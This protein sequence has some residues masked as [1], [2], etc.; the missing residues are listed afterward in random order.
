MT[1]RTFLR[2]SAAVP[3]FV[4]ALPAMAQAERDQG[5]A[6]SAADHDDIVVYA[7][8]RAENLQDVPLSISAYGPAQLDTFAISDTSDLSNIAPNVQ[9]G[10][11]A[12]FRS[13]ATFFIRGI[14][15][16]GVESS[17][18][19]SV[20][21]FVDGVYRARSAGAITK[22]L[23][24]EAVEMLRGPQDALYGR[25]AFA[26]AISAR[27]QRAKLG[28]TEGFAEVEYGNYNALVLNGAINIPLDTDRLALRVAAQYRRD[29]GFMFSKST[30]KHIGGM[31][32]ATFRPQI[33]WK[34]TE[35][36][37]V[38]I[39]GEY[40]QDRSEPSVTQNLYLPGS[41][42]SRV[43][44]PGTNPYGDHSEGIAGDGTS[45]FASEFTPG[46]PSISNYDN[47]SLT[48]LSD[49]DVGVGTVSLMVNYSD[50]KDHIY[51]DTDSEIVS[52]FNSAR[53]Q[54]YRSAQSELRFVSDFSDRTRLIVGGFY[55]WDTFDLEQFIY[56]GFGN[57]GNPGAVPPIAPVP[58]GQ[59]SDDL[60][61]VSYGVNGQRRVSLA[62]FSQLEH[63]LTDRLTVTLGLRYSWEKK[64]AYANP[65]KL[66]L[67][68]DEFYVDP[69]GF[70]ERQ[71]RSW[72]ALSPRIGLQYRADDDVMFFG[73]WQRGYKS[74]GFSTA[75]ADNCFAFYEPYDQEKVD[76]FEIG[77]KTQFFDRRLTL[78]LNVFQA[79]YDSLQR[80]YTIPIPG[81]VGFAAI[82][83]NAAG[84]RIR[85]FEL[86]AM[87]RPSRAFNIR[88]NVGYL[89]PRY[90]NYVADLNGDGIPEDN[91]DLRIIF[92]PTW[93]AR[94]AADYVVDLPA[95]GAIT[96]TGAVSHTSYMETAPNNARFTDRAPLTTVDGSIA[97]DSAD[98]RLRLQ[99]FGRNI[100]NQVERAGGT[101]IGNVFAYNSPTPPRTYGISGRVRF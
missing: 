61:T 86:E 20:A 54:H 66:N 43:G 100:F 21:V 9:L 13:I 80:G 78:N 48:W 87:M 51:T 30:G 79:D 56:T 26:G 85:G 35:D 74:G 76:N 40:F 3:L 14:G 83:G 28:V 12:V 25:N 89:D 7:Q 75:A 22:L 16:Q 69:N 67:K 5:P 53:K 101:I 37:T 96:L 90:T 91:S 46:R 84:A 23:D 1:L 39:I 98:D 93:D 15:Q 45:K 57:P 52:L 65:Y 88:G 33:Q 55:F 58:V 29:D 50:E 71:K 36:F 47:Y 92:A 10:N 8:K 94:V 17:V 68:A 27:S 72:D 97:W 63:D 95:G 44:Y 81:S 99:I 77:A 4:A 42:F 18:D 41:V 6:P 24:V 34:P 70:C 62:A 73:S 31:E 2:A 59:F 64:K 19:P 49:Y 82:T 38:R 32:V 60:R 11:Q